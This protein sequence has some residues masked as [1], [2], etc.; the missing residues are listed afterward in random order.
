M[1]QNKQDKQNNDKYVLKGMI[2]ELGDNLENANELYTNIK[3]M[4]DNLLNKQK[5]EKLQKDTKE[6]SS[7]ANEE[8][9]EEDFYNCVIMVNSETTKGQYEVNYH[10]A[11]CSCPHFRYSGPRK[12]KHLQK[13][14]MN[15]Q[16][17]IPS[18]Y[19]NGFINKCNSY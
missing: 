16:G 19:V 13:L 12:C 7:K 18:Q 6:K 1:Q 2:T 4:V 11:T 9:T 8:K 14:C 5:E 3:K 10:F 15:H 17:R